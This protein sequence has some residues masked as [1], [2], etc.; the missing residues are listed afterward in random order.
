MSF[1][2]QI[3]DA[4]KCTGCFACMNK[5]PKDAISSKMD[6]T[7]RTLPYIDGEKCV[8]CK[9]CLRTCPVNNNAELFEPQICYAAQRRD[10]EN[11]KFSTSGGIAAVLSEYVIAKNGSV[12]GAAVNKVGKVCHIC[13]STKEEIDKLRGSK[14]VQSDIGFSYNETEKEL[15]KG[16]TV[17]FTGTPCQ[18]AALKK[19]LGKD[20]ENLF[21]VDL[22]CH[23][24]PPMQYLKEHYDTVTKGE[25][26]DSVS[27]RNPSIGFFLSLQRNGEVL[28]S[29]DRFHDI[30]FHAFFKSLTYRENCYDCSYAERKRCSDLTIG[31]FWGIDR[32]SLKKIKSGY[33]SIVL[34][35]SDKGRAIFDEIK[36]QL[37]FEE[38]Q[39]SEAVK[40]NRQLQTPSK[41]HK[42]RKEF[43]ETYKELRDFDLAVE[44]IG[45]VKEMKLE[46]IYGKFEALKSKI[47]WKI[48]SVLR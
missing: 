20:Y 42:L 17:L 26:I 34:I 1:D 3:C 40:G 15:Q 39:I 25:N 19:Y 9:L 16:K 8:G 28:Y 36:D 41:K 4:D 46:A 37:I 18:I 13:A 12:F 44:R 47:V 11:R 31:D 24:V 32:K 6:D 5:C 22:I 33:I 27:F 38:R 2:Y 21:C 29:A 30:Y 45:L 10:I 14:Y 48:N 35:N 43:I 7:G 23:G